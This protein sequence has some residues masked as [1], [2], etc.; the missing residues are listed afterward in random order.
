MH[1]QEGIIRCRPL[2]QLTAESVEQESSKHKVLGGDVKSLLM[3]TETLFASIPH[4][5]MIPSRLQER[6]SEATFLRDTLPSELA[7]RGD[8]L[9]EQLALRSKYESVIRR[10]NSWMDEARLRL[11][12]PSNGVDFEHIEKEL[13]EHKVSYNFKRK[14]NWFSV[15]VTVAF[16]RLISTMKT[17]RLSPC[18]IASKQLLMKLCNQSIHLNRMIC[19]GRSIHWQKH[20]KTVWQPPAIVKINWRRIRVPTKIMK[21]LCRKS[22]KLSLPIHNQRRR[23]LQTFRPWKIWLL[24]WKPSWSFFK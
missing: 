20:P 22:S 1:E 18:W 16:Y 21:N 10:L 5:S 4:D 9:K 12:P 3:V 14:N 23:R 24:P 7:A 6:I 8:Y 15:K 17:S 2:L 13:N 11:R 19:K